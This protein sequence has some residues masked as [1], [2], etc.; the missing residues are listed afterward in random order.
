MR[1]LGPADVGRAAS[2][3]DPGIVQG[4]GPA[5][6]T[7]GRRLPA[8]EQLPRG[9]REPHFWRSAQPL[10]AFGSQ[11]RPFSEASVGVTTLVSGGAAASAPSRA[12]GRA[13]RT[14]WK[15]RAVEER[16]ESTNLAPLCRPGAP[17]TPTW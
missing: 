4:A 2:L 5:P 9:S 6:R 10:P 12:A 3:I 15:R 14:R 7:E 8:T 11:L 17:A 16:S 13:A 1:A